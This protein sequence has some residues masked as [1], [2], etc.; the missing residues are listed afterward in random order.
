MH[1]PKNKLNTQG[2]NGTHFKQTNKLRSWSSST[3][4]QYRTVRRLNSICSRAQSCTE[5]PSRSV[6]WRKQTAIYEGTTTK[7]TTAWHELER[8]NMASPYAVIRVQ[9]REGHFTDKWVQRKQAASSGNCAPSVVKQTPL[10]RPGQD[11]W[12]LWRRVGMWVR[13]NGEILNTTE[14]R[15]SQLFMQFSWNVF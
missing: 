14:S 12:F 3:E 4:Y 1:G 2:S 13:K 8:G 15:W 11:V 7:R 10:L 5:E 9:Q 6:L